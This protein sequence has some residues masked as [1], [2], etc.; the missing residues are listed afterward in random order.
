MKFL[1]SFCFLFPLAVFGQWTTNPGTP[2][3]VCPTNSN[4]YGP[5][6]F[7]DGSSGQY[8]FWVDDRGD[9][10]YPSDMKL[11]A[12]H[13]DQN[14]NR[15]FPDSGKLVVDH[16]TLKTADYS[17]SRDGQGKFWIGWGLTTA[18]RMD[19]MVMQKFDNNTLNPIWPK[20]KTI[21]RINSSDFNVL[22]LTSLQ[23]LP[24]ADSAILM[25]MVTW[26]GGS[27]VK[28]VNRISATGTIRYGNGKSFTGY[29]QNYGPSTAL[30]NPDGTLL[31]IQRNG[32]GSGTGVNAWKFDKNL[33]L[34]WGPKSLAP[35]PGLG[36]AFEVVPDGAN[37]F[38]MAYVRVGGDIL[39]TR[40]DS[41]GNFKWTPEQRIICDYSSSQDGPD[42]ERVGNYLY[43]VWKDNRP[44]A[45]NSDIYMQKLDL[46]GNRL[47][48]PDGRRVIRLNSYIPT[49][50]LFAD[51][52]GN[53]IVGSH[54]SSIGFVAQKVM[55]DSTLGWPGYG[56]LIASGNTLVPNYGSFGFGQGANGN[57][58]VAWQGFQS[59]RI[60]VAGFADNG[61]LLTDVQDQLSY[62][63]E[64]QLYPNPA[65]GSV[66]LE[67]IDLATETDVFIFDATGKQVFRQKILQES[68]TQLNFALPGGYYR[69]KAGNKTLPLVIE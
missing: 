69:V 27:T 57:I 43:C 33:T 52:N 35:A 51:A 40:V 10:S 60:F 16:P 37:G 44:P 17:I 42:L 38:V 36:Y 49:P 45:S 11:F 58:F 67:G 31:L 50:R 29:N 61:T 19:S 5:W 64:L 34:N 26:L 68:S 24:I 47:W 9:A 48:N 28:F 14:G 7:P 18:S 6:I 62:K 23:I 55:P 30:T 15:L 12:Q 3:R 53:L 66:Q 1:L 22:Y 63:K 41:S 56:L 13:L 4:Q 39:A 25:Y 32:N 21:A 46:M 59:P 65:W 20:T 54:H 8:I 2:L